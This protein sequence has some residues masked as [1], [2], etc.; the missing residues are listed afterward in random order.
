MFCYSYTEQVS[1]TTSKRTLY[2]SRRLCNASTSVLIATRSHAT[3]LPVLHIGSQARLG[4]P[5]ARRRPNLICSPRSGTLPSFKDQPWCVSI[6]CSTVTKPYLS[7]YIAAEKPKTMQTNQEMDCLHP[8]KIYGNIG[9]AEVEAQSVY[10]RDQ[11]EL[12]RVGK[13]EVLKV[14]QTPRYAQSIGTLR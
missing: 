3:R 5:K 9:D 4:P 13:K 1:K 2:A 8:S 10:D 7:T 6:I 12:A 14:R 11:I